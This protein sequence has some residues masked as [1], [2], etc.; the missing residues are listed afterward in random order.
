MTPIIFSSWGS[1]IQTAWRSVMQFC[2]LL[3]MTAVQDMASFTFETQTFVTFCR[4][5][6]QTTMLSVTATG[7]PL[8]YRSPLTS[9]CK[10]CAHFE[11]R[12]RDQTMRMIPRWS[13]VDKLVWIYDPAPYVYTW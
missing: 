3:L 13:F 10:I 4:P 7:L 12:K 8:R 11:T 9:F 6:S 5:S 2:I 1:S